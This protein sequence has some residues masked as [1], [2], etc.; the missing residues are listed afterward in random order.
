M[1]RFLWILAPAR[2]G[3]LAGMICLFVSPTAAAIREVG[4]VSLGARRSSWTLFDLSGYFEQQAMAVTPDGD[5]LSLSTQRDGNWRLYRVRGWYGRKPIVDH[6]ILPGFFSSRDRHNLETLEVNLFATH[7]GSYAVCV[8][9][10]EWLKR[11]DGRAVGHARSDNMITVVDLSS[12][13]IVNS[14]R[15]KGLDLF[16]FQGVEM[17][18][19]GRI[20]IDSSA[21]WDWRSKKPR[22]AAFIPLEVPS[23]RP[24]AR[25]TYELLPGKPGEPEHPVP[26]TTE[27]CTTDLG[28]ESLGDYLKGSSFN[29]VAARQLTCADT[30]AEY[31]PQPNRFT[32][33][34]RF[35]LG[36][37]TEGH[38]SLFG[39]WVQTRA[40]GVV[41]STRGGVEIGE[42]DLTHHDPT[43]AL[44]SINGHDY[45]LVLR[46][47][48]ELTV[49]QLIDSGNG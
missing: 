21:D 31:C 43:V 10:A 5:L 20:L 37:R 18:R 3:L 24:D 40:T 26:I 35:G 14:R 30:K 8:G 44:A 41:F 23:L 22:L 45:L 9:S 15:T 39:G 17:D 42:L 49:Y 6:L 25:C 13:K 28:S 16:E 46:S 1:L 47:G 48:A 32:P 11:V 38:D 7:D 4:K 12:F 34:R 36:I 27:A 33:D 2:V 29:P 19:R